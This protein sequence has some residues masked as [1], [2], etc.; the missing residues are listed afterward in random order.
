MRVALDLARKAQGLTNPNPAVGGLP[1][2]EVEA[3]KAAGSRSRGA[4]LYVTLEP[5]DHFG[6]T[7]PC[8]QAIIDAG[9]KK[10]VIAMKD[11]N[12]VTNGKGVRKLRARGIK[13]HIG[14]LGKEAAALNGPFI[15]FITTGTICSRP[16]TRASRWRSRSM[17]RSLRGPEIRV[18]YRRRRRD[19]MSTR[20]GARSMPSW[21]ASTPF[22]G[23]TRAS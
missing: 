1:H 12:P 6:R 5:C 20:C 2:A 17:E 23:M 21:S 7:G 22:S 14:I 19:G 13:T 3:L 15:K 8:T 9:I 4:T 10:V 11:P 16:W 18:G